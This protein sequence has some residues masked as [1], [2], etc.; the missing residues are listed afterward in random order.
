MSD[1]SPL[2]ARYSGSRCVAIF[3]RTSAHSRPGNSTGQNWLIFLLSLYPLQGRV[4][5][6]SSHLAAAQER[7]PLE[8]MHVLLVLQQR[9]VQRRDQFARVAF[10]EHFRR[11]VLVEQ[12]LEPV[13]Q[14]R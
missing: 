10:P 6:D 11:H 8:Q 12:E 7:Q 2:C 5:K 1:L 14:L 4:K 3:S 13:Q 9:A